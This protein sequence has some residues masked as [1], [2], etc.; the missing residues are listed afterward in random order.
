MSSRYHLYVLSNLKGLLKHAPKKLQGRSVI[1]GRNIP[2]W[3][4]GFESQTTLPWWCPF[5]SC[6]LDPVKTSTNWRKSYDLSVDWFGVVVYKYEFHQ[7]WWGNLVQVDHFDSS[8][9]LWLCNQHS[10]DNDNLPKLA[11]AM[12]L[13]NGLVWWEWP[14]TKKCQFNKLFPICTTIIVLIYSLS[15]N[16]Q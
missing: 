10:Q 12:N 2:R 6:A 3:G 4:G 14:S 11:G 15:R 7:D 5:S 13:W 16:L 1:S 9:G 8:W